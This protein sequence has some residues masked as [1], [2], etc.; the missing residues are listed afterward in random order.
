MNIGAAW[1][2]MLT[3]AEQRR[4]QAIGLRE[5]PGDLVQRLRDRAYAG[6]PD[7][8]LEEAANEIE[9]LRQQLA[10]AGEKWVVAEMASRSEDRVGHQ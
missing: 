9:R 1:K 6:L 2:Q 4:R 8:L 10:K 5:K 7:P 3:V